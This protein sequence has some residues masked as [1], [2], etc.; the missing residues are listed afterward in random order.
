M[1]SLIGPDLEAYVARHTTPEGDLFA[2]L[3]AETLASLDSP[4][5]QVG[6]VEGALLRI[7]VALV[8]PRTILD[9]GMPDLDQGGKLTVKEER[10]R[11]SRLIRETIE[12][13]EPRLRNLSIEVTQD[14]TQQSRLLV[15]IDG[16][17]ALEDVREPISFQMPLGGGERE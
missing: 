6:Q 8:R 12:A 11:L 13:F 5:M 4:Q 9:F 17:L 3:R 14:E 1:L 10:M 15:N 16:L 7:I 2:R